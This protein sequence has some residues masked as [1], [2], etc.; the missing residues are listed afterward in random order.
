MIPMLRK[1]GFRRE[2]IQ[3]KEDLYWVQA[4]KS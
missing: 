3:E 1:T 4:E 2:R